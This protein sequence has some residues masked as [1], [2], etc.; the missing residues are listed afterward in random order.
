MAAQ[1]VLDFTANGEVFLKSAHEIRAAIKAR[2]H[3]ELRAELQEYMKEVQEEIA[4]QD[5]VGRAGLFLAVMMGKK[6]NASA[7]LTRSCL[8]RAVECQQEIDDLTIIS[9]N[10]DAVQGPLVY[11]LTLK[12]ATRYGLGVSDV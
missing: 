5:A 4:Q 8:A 10:L 9:N 3:N 11:K 12:Q 1:P 2:V 7:L 6:L